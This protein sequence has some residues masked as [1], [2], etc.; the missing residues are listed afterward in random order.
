MR[1]RKLPELNTFQQYL[2]NIKDT[3]G[4]PTLL[5]FRIAFTFKIGVHTTQHMPLR[6]SRLHLK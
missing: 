3:V 4:N 6:L 5:L 1:I 2:P